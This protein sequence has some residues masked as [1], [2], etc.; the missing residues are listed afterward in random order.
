MAK[1]GST[2]YGSSHDYSSISSFQNDLFKELEKP[3]PTQNLDK[4]LKK[5]QTVQNE[6]NRIGQ[7]MQSAFGKGADFSKSLSAL[8]KESKKA[9]EIRNRINQAIKDFE[10]SPKEDQKKYQGKGDN[11]KAIRNRSEA[12]SE[13]ADKIVDKYKTTPSS[14]G[15]EGERVVTIKTEID[16]QSEAT[17]EQKIDSLRA[18]IEEPIKMPVEAET[19]DTA[20]AQQRLSEAMSSAD[21]SWIKESQMSLEEMKATLKELYEE[22]NSIESQTP[23]ANMDASQLQE[24]AQ[25]L[26]SINE[27]SSKIYGEY[28]PGEGP[29]GNNSQNNNASVAQTEQ[30]FNSLQE[31]KQCI[32]ETK[33]ELDSLREKAQSG[34]LVDFSGAVEEAKTL[35]AELKRLE[36]MRKAL[37]GNVKPESGN[38]GQTPNNTS[39]EQTGSNLS[40][41][42]QE[43]EKRMNILGLIKQTISLN[44]QLAGQR[45]ALPF[46]S[47]V[48][49]TQQNIQGLQSQ[50]SSLSSIWASIK[51]GPIVSAFS[52][53][54]SAASTVASKIGQLWNSIRSGVG[55]AVS[56][57]SNL[58]RSGFEKLK[59]AASS[60]HSTLTRLG[61]GGFNAIKSGINTFRS[62]ISS[63]KSKMTSLTKKTTPNLL[64]SLSSL[65]SMLLR[66]IKR[67]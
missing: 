14:R 48:Q 46:S 59:S 4:Y 64:K 9:I 3:L 21:T 49:G 61:N 43:A 29:F 19:S 35:E 5:L 8:E 39:G 31:L 47:D 16:A 65:K 28:A 33:A 53:I 66:R 27:L 13:S 2:S 51:G 56:S 41:L 10:S 36:G 32:E 62:G 20:D 22:K 17:T 57:L 54:G 40:G 24:Y 60:L 37:E 34:N 45:T 67:T 58:A 44:A 11:L 50:L 15:N 30:E 6:I 7:Q 55:S 1:K 42:D 25:V 52:A 23:I 18:K 63:L 26:A 12:I 38:N